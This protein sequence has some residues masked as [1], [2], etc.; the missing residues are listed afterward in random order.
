M[1]AEEASWID[2]HDYLGYHRK[3][4]EF[5]LS[6][7]RRLK[8]E[9]STKVLDIGRSILSW[10]LAEF[11]E[12]VTTLGFPLR[13]LSFSGKE[14][15]YPGKGPSE[16]IVFDLN[17]SV[18]SKIPTDGRYG[19][20]V[21]AETIEHLTIPAE[22]SLFALSELLTEDGVLICQTPNACRFANRA[23][24]ILG[25]NPY[26]KMRFT[27]TN[28]GHV[29]EYTKRELLDAGIRAGL[30]PVQHI[31]KDY[32]KLPAGFKGLVLGQPMRCAGLLFPQL[33]AGQTVV[34]RHA[35]APV[36]GTCIH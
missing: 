7:C 24:I 8:P 29:R 33:R 11:Y 2:A 5:L 9:S 27:K 1:L 34:Y 3:R 26:E 16:H 19:L 17:E 23:R 4:Y 14:V 18:R 20:I 12:Q 10:K 22:L 30:R 31:Y 28:P 32:F 25:R 15:Q 35:T 36:P 13:E 6:L 21:Y